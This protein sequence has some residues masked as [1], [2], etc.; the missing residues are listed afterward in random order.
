VIRE[1]WKLPKILILE[2]KRFG[3][4]ETKNDTKV[5]FP[6]EN[7]DLKSY[8]KEPEITKQIGTFD[9][10][11]MLNHISTLRRERSFPF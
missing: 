6:I 1:V 8:A 9:L 5:K 7:V 4:K 2:L 3:N 10:I 11:G